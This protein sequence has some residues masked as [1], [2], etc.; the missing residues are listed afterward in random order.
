L[1]I[2]KLTLFASGSQ[3]FFSLFYK[4]VGG[5]PGALLILETNNDNRDCGEN[6]LRFEPETSK[7][8]R[9]DFTKTTLF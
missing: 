6:S 5:F 4:K 2:F 8:R 7:K 3:Y 1:D 9:F